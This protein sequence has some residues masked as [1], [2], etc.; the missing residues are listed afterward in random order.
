M[1]SGVG[2]SDSPYH[3]AITS[4]SSIATT[5]ESSIASWAT[6]RICCGSMAVTAGRMGAGK[7]GA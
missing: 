4:G 1:K 6:A 5:F 7:D 2:T 3:S